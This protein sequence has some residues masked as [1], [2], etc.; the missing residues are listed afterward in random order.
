MT[1][2]AELK[3][4]SGPAVG[5]RCRVTAGP[6]AGIEGIVSRHGGATQIILEVS[7]LAQGAALEIDADLVEPIE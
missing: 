3:L 2:P 5:Q 4:H 1:G 7:V 6:F